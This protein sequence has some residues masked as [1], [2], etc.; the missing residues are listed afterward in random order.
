LGSKASA[1]FSAHSISSRAVAPC[2]ETVR[3]ECLY[4]RCQWLFLFVNIRRTVPS[5][6]ASVFLSGL[7]SLAPTRA[8]A[9]TKSPATR[10]QGARF[11][12]SYTC[13]GTRADGPHQTHF[14]G[15][16]AHSSRTEEGMREGGTEGR[17]EGGSQS[18][19]PR[20][21]SRPVEASYSH[22]ALHPQHRCWERVAIHRAPLRLASP[23][24]RGSGPR[25]L[26]SRGWLRETRRWAAAEKQPG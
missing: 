5:A 15:A 24:P 26:R 21:Q 23:G 17:R 25:K 12:L 9:R 14:S 7:R 6:R 20:K 8:S 19:R 3:V 13:Q 11:R 4:Y 16:Q 1:K 18:C 10:F 2:T 22:A